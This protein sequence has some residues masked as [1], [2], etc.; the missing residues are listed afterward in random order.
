[1]EWHLLPVAERALIVGAAGTQTRLQ[2]NAVPSTDA[3]VQ[4]QA[5]RLRDQPL[6]ARLARQS[7]QLH[8]L[9]LVMQVH[10]LLDALHLTRWEP[11]VECSFRSTQRLHI[12]LDTTPN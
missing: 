7:L 9:E 11:V 3:L 6:Q 1:M 2:M 8:L 12:L 10:D 5:H 4:L